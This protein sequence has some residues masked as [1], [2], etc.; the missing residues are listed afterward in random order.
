VAA[1]EAHAD[2]AA[3]EEEPVPAAAAA[4]GEEEE[5]QEEKGRRVA[6]AGRGRK[7]RRRGAGAPGP[8]SSPAPAPAPAGPRGGLVMVKRDL[9]ARCMTCP[10]CRRLLR[11]ATTISECLHTCESLPPSLPLSSST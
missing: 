5:E 1:P 9:L 7:R 3:P 8:S 6:A 2:D 11:D 10:L 4:A